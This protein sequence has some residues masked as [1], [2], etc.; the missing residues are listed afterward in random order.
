MS[1]TA[2]AGIGVFAAVLVDLRVLRTR[3]LGTK[4]F[5]LAYAIIVAFQLLVNGVL[6]GLSIV[7]Y[8]PD[9]ILGV[10]LAYAPIEDIAFG[11][12]MTV[13]TLASWVWVGRRF[14]GHG[15]QPPPANLPTQHRESGDDADTPTVRRSRPLRA[16][17]TRHQRGYGPRGSVLSLGASGGVLAWCAAA[18]YS[19][20]LLAG[21]AH[22]PLPA[23]T[24]L[25]SELEATGQP[26]HLFFRLT[27]VLSGI[28]IL[29][30]AALCTRC[31]PPTTRARSGCVLLTVLGIAT[32]ADGATQ[33]AC[34]PSIDVVCRD[35]EESVH[36]LLAQLAQ[37]H[38]VSGLIGFAAATS[39]ML[40]IGTATETRTRVFRLFSI[41]CGLG[42][43][44]L[45][46]IDIP[47][48][49][50]NSVI[51]LGERG[52]ILLISIWLAGLG[53]RMLAHSF[54]PLRLRSVWWWRNARAG[55]LVSGG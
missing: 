36:G 37:L 3:L 15:T 7:R 5:W 42:V 4:A 49:L 44:S 18:T 40:L 33:M 21:W 53:V 48:L 41:G 38:T 31:L 9:A 35:Q 55:A 30:V 32:I 29:A 54:A 22:S 23:T 1:Y 17:D 10:R 25:V 52:R 47:L 27:G 26:H 14:A 20:F 16:A 2:L 11:F 12:A 8:N 24:S 39:A 51:G 45:G 6:T 13:L 19:S 34:A 28:A 43:A 46:L 50:T